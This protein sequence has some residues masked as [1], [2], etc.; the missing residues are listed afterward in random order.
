MKRMIILFLFVLFTIKISAQDLTGY[1]LSH[2]GAPLAGA[3]ILVKELSKGTFT[4]E[5]GYFVIKNIPAG[6]YK[7]EIS[8]VGY[9]KQD[10]RISIPR[11]N[12]PLKIILIEDAV[13]TKQ[14]IVTAS[15]HEEKIAELPVSAIAI[16]PA[17]LEKK[18][19]LSLDEALRYV[20]GINM[21]LD[22]ISIRGSSGYSKGAG[23]RV[24]TAIDGVP[25]YTGDTGETIWEMVPI[26]NIERIEIIKG[27]ASSLYG[28][29]AIGGVIN[30]ITRKIYSKPITQFTSYAGFYASPYHSEWKWSDKTRGFYGIGL[31]HS[32]TIDRL[33]YSLSLKRTGNDG[34]REND[35]NRRILG[36]LKLSYEFD[37]SNALS[38][39][40]SYLNMKRGNFLYWKDGAHALSPKDEDN[41]KYVKSDRWFASI[42][43]KHQ[44]SENFSGEIKS[45][46]YDTKFDGIGVEV[47][48]SKS[49]LVRNELI[50]YARLNDVFG[51]TTGAEFSYSKITSNIFH[52]KDFST[53]S[54]Y[55]QIEYKGINKLIATL[56]LRYDYIKLDSLSGASAVTS[57]IGLNYR[58]NENLILRSSFG[59]GFR[60]PTPAE[61][62]T[63]SSVGSI[64]IKE[65]PALTFEKSISFDAGALITAAQN[66]S[67]DI[68]V[69]YNEY[70]NF[71]EP[72]LLNTG[73]IQFVNLPKAKIEGFEILNDNRFLNGLIKSNIG[74]TYL[75][76]RDI[77]NNSPMKY[78]PRHTVYASLSVN[79]DPFE[80]ILDFRYISKAEKTDA[81]SANPLLA[82]VT[83]GN[84]RVDAYIFDL[85]AG[86]GFSAGRLPVRIYFNCKNLFNYNYVEFIG[87]VAPIRSYTLSLDLFF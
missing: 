71:I 26:T 30:V 33:G 28:S 8:Y 19:R 37:S 36:T 54:A 56:G 11:D 52:N 53:L 81:D 4:S 70:N 23:T 39:F 22:Q 27:P 84:K 65:N 25:L 31:N 44:F 87:N 42:V 60:A 32:N 40:T 46:I 58:I 9:K 16:V 13:T 12:N 47:T 64:Q 41:G 76:S 14:I 10:I 21:S 79:P 75:W 18:N 15:K 49:S 43:Y 48:T 82:L 45:S 50:T 57:K 66:V 72:K 86:Y 67:F 24:L 61:V 35:F 85:S 62:F 6:N 7:I 17:D 68:S 83:D 38:L 3:S 80:F 63:T 34:Y 73:Y 69:F 29:T 74:Y 1:V 5:T 77:A 59:T 51:L 2:E 55:S 20:P 78:R